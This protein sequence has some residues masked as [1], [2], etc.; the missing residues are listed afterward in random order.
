VHMTAMPSLEVLLLAGRAAFLVVCFV[1][2]SITFIAWR[3]A[4]RRQTEHIL[5][6]SDSLL[7]RLDA[8]Q[9]RV[10]AAATVL[11]RLDERFER[12]AQGGA[13]AQGYQIAIRLARGGASREEL[14]SSCGLSLG[15][16]EL[17]RRLHGSPRCAS[18]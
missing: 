3:H 9:A 17:V 15:E 5:A 12:H 10:D 1:L 18:A 11:T 16:A 14:V 13:P 6:Q 2:A 7:Q 8:L 4:T